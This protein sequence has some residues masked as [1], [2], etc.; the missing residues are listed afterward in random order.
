M[1][2][3]AC[4]SRSV[5][6]DWRAKRSAGVLAKRPALTDKPKELALGPDKISPLEMGYIYEELLKRFSEQSGEEAGDH[7]TPREVVRL[8]VELP[9]IPIPE[10][11]FSIY[12]PAA[13]T[14]GML[15][16]SI[17][18][19]RDFILEFGYGFCFVVRSVL[20]ERSGS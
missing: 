4:P 5:L 13:G 7:F 12:S 16:V 6:I 11:H 3:L 15:S 14:G 2:P 18:R 9:D 8:M 19:L 20:P 17:E 1:P 10:K